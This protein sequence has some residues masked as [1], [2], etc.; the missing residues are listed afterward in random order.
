MKFS[1]LIGLIALL[2]IVAAACVGG[3]PIHYYAIAG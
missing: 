3:R 2:C 1:P